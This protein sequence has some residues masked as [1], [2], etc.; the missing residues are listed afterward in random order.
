MIS[1]VLLAW[2]K[3]EGGPGSQLHMIQTKYLK[4]FLCTYVL[5]PPK[6]P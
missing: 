6:V 5:E 4:E 1:E 2:Q 3:Y